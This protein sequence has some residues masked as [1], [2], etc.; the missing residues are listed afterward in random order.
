MNQPNNMSNHQQ[1]LHATFKSEDTEEWLDKVFTRP[2]GLL[3]A[4]LFN[5]FDVHPNTVTILSIILGVA[6]GV[7]FVFQDL[8][9]NLIGVCLLVWANIYDSTDGQMARMTGK[10]T[11][12]GRILDGAAGDFWFFAIY[13][14]LV[15]RMWHMQV[16]ATDLTFQ[17]TGLLLCAIAS[18][19]C[20][21][22]QCRLADYYRNIHLF[23]VKGKKGSEL[24]TYEQQKAIYEQTT[25]QDG[26]IVGIFRWGYMNYT[27]AQEKDTPQFQKLM[28]T[29]RQ[30][31]GEDI[32]DD[33]RQEFRR[34]SLPLMKYTNI[35]TFNTRAIA[36]YVSCL[37]NMPYLYPL[38]EITV[39]TS[40]SVYMR[41]RHE[42]MCRQLNDQLTNG[43]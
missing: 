22:P 36:L 11:L 14:S 32:P 13:L 24:D 23:F 10:K 2:V 5:H 42:M 43:Y 4:R 25:R 17:W 35:L 28:A 38:F 27:R 9:H 3:W 6:A 29:L 19:G 20:H 41:S 40:L 15:I 21:G 37:L 39:L 34:R 12:I 8:T 7:M 26:L 31:Y 30:R 33:F 18:L 16:P 1:Q